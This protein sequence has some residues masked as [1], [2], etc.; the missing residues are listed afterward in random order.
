[1]NSPSLPPGTVHQL[2]IAVIVKSFHVASATILVYDYL[3]TFRDE[4]KLIW[5]W[6]WGLGKVL[7]FLTRYLAFVDI[8]IFLVYW[9]DQS[10]NFTACRPLITAGSWFLWAG[11]TIAQY[12]ISLRTYALFGRSKYI[13]FALIALNMGV[14]IATIILLNSYLQK[15]VYI[16]TP[17]PTVITCFTEAPRSKLYLDYA[18]IM[19]IEMC[20]IGLTL[21]RGIS[22][23]RSVNSPLIGTLYRDGVTFFLCLFAIS[24]TNFILYVVTQSLLLELLLPEFQRVMHSVLTARIVLHLRAAAAESDAANSKFGTVTSILFNPA[25]HAKVK[26]SIE[27]GDT[28]LEDFDFGADVSGSSDSGT[29]VGTGSMS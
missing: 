4:A 16:P 15:L 11:I 9:F 17:F 14:E 25:E 26:R 6:K 13:G 10:L 28:E 7:F 29:R 20:I 18:L 8:T 24:F 22:E 3:L 1:M 2:N 21:W 27:S 12:I 5:P 23:W 19:I